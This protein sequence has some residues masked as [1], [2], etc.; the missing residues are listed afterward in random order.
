[1]RQRERVDTAG[2][3]TARR[4]GRRQLYRVEDPHIIAV[5]NQMFSHIAPDRTLTPD[6]TRRRPPQRPRFDN[7]SAPVR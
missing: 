3:V 5:I 4:D 6:P 7:A 1:M 2:V